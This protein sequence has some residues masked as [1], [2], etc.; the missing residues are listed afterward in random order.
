[1]RGLALVGNWQDN[2][3]DIA[4]IWRRGSVVRMSVCSRQRW[5]KYLVCKYKYEYKYSDCKYKYTGLP[6]AMQMKLNR[7][8][9]SW[10][11]YYRSQFMGVFRGGAAG[12]TAPPNRKIF[13]LFKYSISSFL[14]N[15]MY[16]LCR[17][18]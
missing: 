11:S 7:I 10:L 13:A 4:Y 8:H 1:M 14:P 18:A 6:L 2:E 16:S 5:H 9:E 17:I 12:A 15:H 3:L